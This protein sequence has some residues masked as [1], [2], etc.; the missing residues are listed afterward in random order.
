ARGMMNSKSAC[1]FARRK[2][3]VYG[4]NETVTSRRLRPSDTALQYQRRGGVRYR[5]GARL[6]EVDQGL[7]EVIDPY[8]TLLGTQESQPHRS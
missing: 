2:L 7:C 8:R 3:S 6:D 4:A 5:K 1:R